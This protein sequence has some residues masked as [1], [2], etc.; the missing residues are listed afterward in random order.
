MT[1]LEIKDAIAGGHSNEIRAALKSFI[2]ENPN[3]EEALLLYVQKL[4]EDIGQASFSNADT[5]EQFR[6]LFILTDQILDIN[7][8]NQDIKLLWL[9]INANFNFAQ[10]DIERYRRYIADLK[11]TSKF[12]FNILQCEIELANH[13]GKK[14]KAVSL[15]YSLLEVIDSVFE[16]R[17]ERD[18]Y[19]SIYVYYLT[20]LLLNDDIAG[21]REAY[22]LVEKY[23]RRLVYNNTYPILVYMGLAMDNR[24]FKLIDELAQQLM[25]I[26]YN[27][28]TVEEHDKEFVALGKTALAELGFSDAIANMFLNLTYQIEGETIWASHMKRLFQKHPHSLYLQYAYGIH[29][30]EME[31]H[32]EAVRYLRNTLFKPYVETESVGTYL[33]SYYKTYNE[34]PELEVPDFE[35][36]SFFATT[37]ALEL[38]ELYK[39]VAD[40]EMSDRVISITLKIL[41]RA[42]QIIQDYE[43]LGAFRSSALMDSHNIAMSYHNY[44]YYANHMEIETDLALAYSEKSKEYSTFIAQDMVH[45]SL[46]MQLG[47]NQEA[48]EIVQVTLSKNLEERS[49]GNYVKYKLQEAVLLEKV[50]RREESYEAYK[51]GKDFM[52]N[53]LQEYGRQN[54]DIGTLEVAFEADDIVFA[55]LEGNEDFKVYTLY[56]YYQFFPKDLDVLYRLC[57][58]Y[59]MYGMWEEFM[60]YAPIY[61][62]EFQEQDFM[63]NDEFMA[64]MERYLPE[65]YQNDP[66][67]VA[68]WLNGFIDSEQ[69]EE[70]IS[71]YAATY[72]PQEK[73][74]KKGL[75][76]R[77][78]G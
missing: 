41:N 28:Y 31:N 73:P 34:V 53:F 26:I 51:R 24:D 72:L 19:I 50:G 2:E 76:G 18:H 29:C 40:K 48:L 66:E 20:V 6:E 38:E 59:I 15:Y 21:Q 10:T 55:Y 56:Q 25:P 78:F 47:R 9:Q 14:E 3:H 45:L 44:A 16:S 30:A 36:S 27:D 33:L 23:V 69:E 46:L 67:E 11:D 68:Y 63:W 17:L 5:D 49:P 70:W 60:T 71:R 32:E 62:Q 74:E 39:I 77:L 13:E 65:L 58:I 37:S 35:G 61:V 4:N 1:F 22:A 52:F 54:F 42:I 43:L 75:F 57:K 7:P 64:I 8:D 12:R